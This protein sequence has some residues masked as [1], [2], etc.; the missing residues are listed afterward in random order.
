MKE[1]RARLGL[2]LEALAHLR[3]AREMAEQH[4]HHELATE[5]H[6]LRGVDARHAAAWRGGGRCDSGR[7]RRG[8]AGPSPRRASPTARPTP[9]EA[10]ASS[11]CRSPPIRDST[12]RS[13]DR[14]CVRLPDRSRTKSCGIHGP[15][16]SKRSSE[17]RRSCCE[18][19]LF[20]RCAT[21][22][23][24]EQEG[25]AERAREPGDRGALP[26]PR[27][28]GAVR[29]SHRVPRA[30][31][32]PMRSGSQRHGS[33]RARARAPRSA[34]RRTRAPP[35]ARRSSAPATRAACRR[36]ERRSPAAPGRRR[37][38]RRAHRAAA[39]TRPSSACGIVR[40]R[41][42]RA[43]HGSE[44]AHANRASHPGASGAASS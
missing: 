3:I 26:S 22:F 5:L 1:L 2:A 37:R 12:F 44:V 32:R 42:R 31:P 21:P 27:R 13:R 43:H 19:R 33:R 29:E 30:S 34:P 10:R 41:G 16:C 7:P 40:R 17:K 36:C 14:T 18:H 11:D 20:E 8:G 6:V 23:V 9:R 4:L 38:V 24:F 25:D 35:R 39:R 15:V 28:R